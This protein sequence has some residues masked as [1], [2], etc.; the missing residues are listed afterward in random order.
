MQKEN[1]ES[2]RERGQARKTTFD[3]NTSNVIEVE[4]IFVILKDVL[5]KAYMIERHDKDVYSAQWIVFELS[6]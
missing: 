1:E 5:V 4:A 3:R 6:I 2:R